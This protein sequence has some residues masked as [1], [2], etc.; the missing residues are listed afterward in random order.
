VIGKIFLLHCSM[1]NK[2]Y[3][4]DPLTTFTYFLMLPV[5]QLK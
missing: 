5:L 2:F 3:G 1:V 4:S